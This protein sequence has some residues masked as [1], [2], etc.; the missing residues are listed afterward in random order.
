MK[1][2]EK[3]I[4]PKLRFKEFEDGWNKK[5]L[6]TLA[7][8]V[9]DKNNCLL[10]RVLTNSAT[11]GILDQKKYF[12][13]DIVTTA[14]ISN[15]FVVD[16]NDYVYNPRIS[17]NAPVGPISKNHIGKGVMSPLYTVFRFRNKE[18]DFFEHFFNSN[19]WHKYILDE[20]NTGAR[21]DRISIS[22]AKFLNMPIALPTKR[23][24]Q[25]KIADCLTSLDELITA[26]SKKLKLLKD[27]KKGLMQK[28]FPTEGKTMPEW[29][30][31][32]FRDS[33]EWEVQQISNLLDYE[34]PDKY[35]V[36]STKYINKGTPVLTANKGFV[37]G[38]TSETNGLYT[39][40]PVIIFDDFTVD[41]K[42]V[43]FTFKVKSSAIKILKAKNKNNLKFIY[44]LMQ[45]IRF[46]AD[47]HK[48]YY[49]S[50]YQTISVAI[51]TDE[52]E[53]Q[54]IADCLSSVDNLIS[55][56]SNKI[57]QLKE[58]KKGLM[59]GLFPSVEEVE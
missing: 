11:D 23:E 16:E 4:A 28:L 56:Q 24:E 46:N 3:I 54:K 55:E 31:P 33:G 51:P 35:I 17:A 37:L 13:R 19:H 7:D 25:Q 27:H 57:E 45:T 29:R 21:F 47:E 41:N 8:K 43:D 52:K 1:N 34:R 10:E 30:F 2:K 48:R 49:I 26:E 14:N 44:E 12:E 42:Y 15:Y 9:V 36:Q 50:A 58:H 53:Q 39:D 6:N 40:T 32:E 20:A 59:Q 38:Y 5:M 22:D 18:N